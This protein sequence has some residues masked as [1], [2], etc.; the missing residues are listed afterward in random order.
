MTSHTLHAPTLDA[1]GTAAVDGT[2]AGDYVL[3]AA[4]SRVQ[5]TT[6]HLFGLARVRGAMTVR[7]GTVTVGTPIERSSVTVSL[8]SASFDSG[9]PQRDATVCSSRFLDAEHFPTI[10]FTATAFDPATPAIAGT[11]TV[12]GR[13]LP[14]QLAVT[15]CAVDPADDSFRVT[16]T[17]EIDRVAAGIT[18]ARGLAARRLQI[19]LDVR[20]VRR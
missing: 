18:A 4:R 16:A 6:R 5:F 17:T 19:E 2:A 7:A 13:E 9:S 14:V 20:C 3:D 12:R 1:L 11:L 15:G 10:V 8:R